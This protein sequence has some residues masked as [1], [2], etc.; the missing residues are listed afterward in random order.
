MGRNI[1]KISK[2]TKRK[3]RR[4]TKR[5]IRRNTKRKI[6]RNTKSYKKKLKGGMM[7]TQAEE[8][9]LPPSYELTQDLQE[10]ISRKVEEENF[11]FPKLPGGLRRDRKRYYNSEESLPNDWITIDY[12]GSRDGRFMYWTD[13]V[14]WRNSRFGRWKEG[15]P[16]DK[17]KSYTVKVKEDGSI[18][19]NNF[20]IHGYVDTNGTRR[21]EAWELPQKNHPLSRVPGYLSNTGD[22]GGSE[23]YYIHDKHIPFGDRVHRVKDPKNSFDPRADKDPEWLE[24]ISAAH[25]ELTQKKAEEEAARAEAEAAQAEK[26]RK[27]FRDKMQ[28]MGKRPPRRPWS[29]GPGRRSSAPTASTASTTKGPPV[30]KVTPVLTEP[31]LPPGWQMKQDPESGRTYYISP[32]GESQWE[33]PSMRAPPPYTPVVEAQLLVMPEQIG[34]GESGIGESGIGES[35]ISN[36]RSLLVRTQTPEQ[37]LK[38]WDDLESEGW[39]RG[40]SASTGEVYYISPKG[41]SQWAYPS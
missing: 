14:H 16:D 13:Q 38:S 24:L 7:G 39:K 8:E 30:A 1:N 19:D 21:R 29:M 10:I 2:N 6:H 28:K 22:W 17:E 23:Y 36:E 34:I 15:V 33:F 40:M 35:G 18:Y 20:F 9:G 12:W 27:Q 31:S 32:G 5:K 37:A 3:I 41:T 26:K 4:N 25:Q 11:A